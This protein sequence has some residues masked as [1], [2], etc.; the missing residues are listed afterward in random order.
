MGL[1]WVK[2]NHPL[3]ALRFLSKDSV[4][5]R[6]W[7]S[8]A[9][10]WWFKHANSSVLLVC[11]LHQFFRCVALGVQQHKE[12]NA[13]PRSAAEKSR[14]FNLKRNVTQWNVLV[15]S[16]DLTRLSLFFCRQCHWTISLVHSTKSYFCIACNTETSKKTRRPFNQMKAKLHF[17]GN[18][19]VD[20][21][22]V[23]LFTGRGVTHGRLETRIEMIEPV[24]RGYNPLPAWCWTD[25]DRGSGV[26]AWPLQCHW[27]V[28]CGL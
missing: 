23:I 20:K 24:I 8:F 1:L 5:S 17:I 19:N 22:N 2:I 11:L 27:P 26:R 3:S 6:I 12:L 25:A 21:K 28:T 15:K 18:L 13:S 14:F 4:P 16:W 10:V 7:F 9:T